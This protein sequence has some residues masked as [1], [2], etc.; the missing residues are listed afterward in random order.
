[1]TELSDWKNIVV[2]QQDPQFGCIPCGFEWMIRYKG[3][4]GLKN[5]FQKDVS[6]GR[7]NSFD[8][9]AIEVK[10][11]Y[12]QIIVK[13]Q[14]FHDG[15]RTVGFIRNHIEKNLPCL[16][17]Y[18]KMNVSG[19]LEGHAVPVVFVN[20]ETI[21]V[22]SSTCESGN[23]TQEFPIASFLYWYTKCGCSDVAWLDDC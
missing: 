11:Q 23:Q 3:I 19:K 7:N 16:I 12:P 10:K 8:S 21:K 13:H 2:V 22:I 1:M 15:E 5:T 4:E 17:V 18:P 6:L 9:V 14:D 20:G